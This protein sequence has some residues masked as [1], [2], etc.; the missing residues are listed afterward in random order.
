MARRTQ[1]RHARIT[2]NSSI[3]VQWCDD[4]SSVKHFAAGTVVDFS[5]IGLRVE[6]REPILPHT[7]VI[8]G[9]PGQQRA[10][11]AGWVRHCQTAGISHVVGIELSAG[12]RWMDMGDSRRAHNTHN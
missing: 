1:R 3:T 11:W 6:L 8:L 12:A 10:G 7:Y 9:A 4:A 5:E 2:A